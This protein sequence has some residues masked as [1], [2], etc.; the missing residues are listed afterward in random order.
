MLGD[1]A[2]HVNC[3]T[4]PS[5]QFE[6]RE[7]RDDEV[8]AILALWQATGS[9]PSITDTP[10]HLRMLSEKRPTFSLSPRLDGRLVGSIIGGWDNWRGHIYRLAVHPTSAAAA[11]PAR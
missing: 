5:M 6:I 2:E 8:E 4:I 3:R 7:A 1:C 9:G 10:E 11:S